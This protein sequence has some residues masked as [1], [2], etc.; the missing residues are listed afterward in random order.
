MFLECGSEIVYLIFCLHS[1]FMFLCFQFIL[2]QKPLIK[3]RKYI[4]KLWIIISEEKVCNICL[5]AYIVSYKSDLW[6]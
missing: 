4:Y 5:S 3:L 6:V 1:Y 2:I